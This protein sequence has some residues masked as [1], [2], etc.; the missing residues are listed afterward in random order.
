MKFT[1]DF[2]Q[3]IRPEYW[4]DPTPGAGELLFLILALII[5]TLLLLGGTATWYLNQKYFKT[6]TPKRDFFSKVM[7]TLF[8]FS[9]VGYLL[10][11]FRTQELGWVSLRL[12]WP[13]LLIS[14]LVFAG[15]FT[16]YYRTRIPGQIKKI[17]EDSLKKKYFRAPKPKKKR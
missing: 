13:L 6:S 16:Y 8:S 5:S 15:Y 3:F 17:E 14:F 4:V 1:L 9:A 11:F 2:S 12:L 7:W 10:T